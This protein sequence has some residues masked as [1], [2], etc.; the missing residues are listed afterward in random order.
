MSTNFSIDEHI[1]KNKWL[2]DKQLT[3]IA[4]GDVKIGAIVTLNLAMLGGLAAFFD[5]KDTTVLL[6]IAY[7]LTAI[8]IITSIS[9]CKLGFK[10]KFSPPNDSNIFFG[11][12]INKDLSIYLT[13][14]NNLSKEDFSTDLANQTYRNAHIACIKYQ[15]LS[16]ATL[17]LF[18]ASILWGVTIGVTLFTNKYSI[19]SKVNLPEPSLKVV[20]K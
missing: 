15:Y 5:A 3:W 17:T 10:P 7:C 16:K 14:L 6:N 4:N 19:I 20:V 2:L 18:I 11:T 12:I 1:E 9:F 8:I 13:D